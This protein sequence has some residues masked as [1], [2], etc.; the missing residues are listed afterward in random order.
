MLSVK[1]ILSA[2]LTSFISF[3]IVFSDFSVYA[4]NDN[5]NGEKITEITIYP[6]EGHKK[7][8]PYIYGINDNTDLSDVTVNAVKQ[9]GNLLTSYNWETNYYNTGSEKGNLNNFSL[10]DDYSKDEL[11]KPGILAY[12]L[13]KKADKYDIPMKLTTLPM[14]GY[15]AADSYGEVK[16]ENSIVRFLNTSFNKADSYLLVPNK[17]D[18]KVYIDEYISYLVSKYNDASNGGFNG[19][20]LDSEPE[21]WNQRFNILKPDQLTAQELMSKSIQLSL[22]VKNIDPDAVVFGPSV[23]N[24]SSYVN[25]NNSNDWQNYSDN[26]TWFIDFYLSSFYEA[27]KQSGRRTLDVLDLHYFTEAYTMVG[28][29]V[30]IGNDTLSNSERIQSVR[31]LWDSTYT[32]NSSPVLLNKQHTPII[33]TVQASIRM[34]YP[35]TK[36]SFSEYSFGGGSNISGGIAQ[37][38]VLGIFAAN[39][40]YM[41]GLVPDISCSYQK[42]AINLYTNYDGEGSSFG[43]TLVKSDNGGDTFSSVYSSVSDK[44]EKTLKSVIINKDVNEK[45]TLISIDSPVKFVS[46]SVY[47][48]DEH[49]SEIRLVDKITDIAGNDFEYTLSPLTVYMFEF[50]GDQVIENTDSNTDNHKTEPTESITQEVQTETGISESNEIITK[51]SLNESTLEQLESTVTSVSEITESDDSEIPKKSVPVFVKIV[52][53]VLVAAVIIIMVYVYFFECN[54]NKYKKD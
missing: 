42:S 51:E 11:D 15:V 30:I 43:E 40:V 17:N 8:S 1:K 50:N 53:S 19:Y 41:A 47:A 32:E 39:D 49:N 45:K 28:T 36:L 26:Y 2:C 4:E 33:P 29:P 3:N 23:R 10:A 7:I 48:F 38:D 13:M 18:D 54:K 6:N 44:F 31:T 5:V 16:V 12:D 9:P 37:A 52:V 24:I 22:T 20:F 27:E 34:Y 35:D 14:M 21:Y 25:M 46:A